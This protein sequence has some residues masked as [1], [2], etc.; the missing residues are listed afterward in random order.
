MKEKKKDDFTII[1]DSIAKDIFNQPTKL[2]K[3]Y[4]GIKN[5]I[6][7]ASHRIVRRKR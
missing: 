2:R 4:E 1:A 7:R 6:R 5:T 3:I